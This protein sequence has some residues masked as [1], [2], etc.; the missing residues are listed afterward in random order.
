MVLSV[1]RMELEQY[2]QE[3][4]SYY[5]RIYDKLLL[6]PRE[7][8]LAMAVHGGTGPSVVASLKREMKTAATAGGVAKPLE[9]D[10]VEQENGETDKRV[11][12][13]LKLQAEQLKN[14]S[15]CAVHEAEKA[16]LLDAGK[17]C[18]EEAVRIGL[19]HA[20]TK[21]AVK[22]AGKGVTVATSKGVSKLVPVIGPIIAGSGFALYRLYSGEYAKAGAELV[23][24]VVGSVPGVGTAASLAIDAGI[25]G[26]DV[27]DAYC[28][29]R[30]GIFDTDA[31]IKLSE[32]L[33]KVESLIKDCQFSLE[34]FF[35]CVFDKI[36]AKMKASD[37]EMYIVN[38]IYGVY[39]D[40]FCGELK[41]KEDRVIVKMQDMNYRTEEWTNV[42]DL[43]LRRN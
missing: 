28:E 22:V 35:D 10:A 18:A 9:K 6:S 30:S 37:D 41:V 24:G 31:Y 33:L 13:V 14:A 12:L 26:W 4:L 29:G 20:G 25:A 8:A 3:C 27:Y 15:A 17:F 21:A 39:R 1:L 34:E 36:D 5:D 40:L 38:Y 43:L 23:S 7:R 16:M 19:K 11:S 32:L 42:R 2:V